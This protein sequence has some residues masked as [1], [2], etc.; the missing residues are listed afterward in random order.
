MSGVSSSVIVHVGESPVFSI[1]DVRQGL[2]RTGKCR[3]VS[4]TIARKRAG[5]LAGGTSAWAYRNFCIYSGLLSVLHN[6]RAIGPTAVSKK[7]FFFYTEKIGER[8]PNTRANFRPRYDA[9]GLDSDEFRKRSP[10]RDF[11]ISP[12]RHVKRYTRT[13][14]AR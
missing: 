8:Q 12:T 4:A 13:A 2:S 3:P 9:T 1:D 7:M 6:E 5:K 14:T 11:S 10:V